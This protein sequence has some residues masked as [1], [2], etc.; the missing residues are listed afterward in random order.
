MRESVFDAMSVGHFQD[1]LHTVFQ[2]FG[3]LFVIWTLQSYCFRSLS[4]SRGETRRSGDVQIPHFTADR[5]T[6]YRKPAGGS[7]Q[8]VTGL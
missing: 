4:H 2:A 6:R 3:E 7:H 8:A 1:Y 5:P